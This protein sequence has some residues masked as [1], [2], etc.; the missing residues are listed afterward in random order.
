MRL[1]LS[2]RLGWCSNLRHYVRRRL[3]IG[4]SWSDLWLRYIVRGNFLPIE[5][6]CSNASVDLRLADGGRVHIVGD[7]RGMH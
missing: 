3:T 1:R 2:Y 4:S 5:L 6:L 7:A